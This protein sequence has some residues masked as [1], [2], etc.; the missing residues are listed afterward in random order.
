MLDNLSGGRVILGLGRGTGK[1]EF[2][3][4]QTDMSSARL[5]FKES[6]EMVLD[7]LET[8]VAE[9]K[10][11]LIEQPRVEIRPRPFKSF[12]GRTY[13]AA[14]SPESAKIM[15]EMGVAILIVPQKP[16]KSVQRELSEYRAIY[17]DATG[18]EPPPPWVSGWTFVDEDPDRA[19]EMARK[20]IGGYWD[21]IVRHYQFDQPHLK[22]T[23]GYEHHGLMY[24]RL[25]EPG[26][27]EKMTDFFLGL[28]PHGTPEQVFDMIV[29]IQEKTFMD[30]Y[31]GVFSYGGMPIEDALHSMKL[32]AREVMPELKKL[33]PVYERL[34]PAT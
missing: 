20:Y 30:G 33:S 32:F 26:G 34:G 15:A 18:Q 8:G 24:D 25:K 3:G 14:I 17:R 19:E 22:T 23:P 1:I 16:W 21:S 6:A 2:D 11:E 4:Y 29:N 12:R 5:R 9:Y 31:T 27:M 28:Q 7:A 13:A 10:G